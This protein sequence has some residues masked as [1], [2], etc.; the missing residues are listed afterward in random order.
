MYK[1]FV[2]SIELGT[3][4]IVTDPCYP[5]DTWCTKTL[6]NVLSGNFKCWLTISNIVQNQILIKDGVDESILRFHK[7][8]ADIGVD[9]GQCG[10]FDYNYYEIKQETDAKTWYSDVCNI[11]LSNDLGGIVDNKGLVSS[12]GWGDGSYDLYIATNENGEIIGIKLIFDE[13]ENEN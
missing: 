3:T 10:V 7:V 11:T 5:L 2:G 1:K 13:D 12:S 4:V 8:D 9:S 6:E